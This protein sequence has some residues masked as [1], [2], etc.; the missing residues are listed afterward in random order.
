[1]P[2]VNSF[3]CTAWQRISGFILTADKPFYLWID[4]CNNWEYNSC[5][6]NSWRLSLI[7]I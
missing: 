5:N 3:V 7:H 2:A 4:K 1:M 6:Y